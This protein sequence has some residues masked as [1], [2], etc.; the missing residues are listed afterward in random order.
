MLDYSNVENLLAAID[1]KYTP[2][3]LVEILG[4]TNQDVFDKFLD[5]ILETNW[6]GLL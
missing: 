4:L 2:E 1:D 6:K 5:E 3:E